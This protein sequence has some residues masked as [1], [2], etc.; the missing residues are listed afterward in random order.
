[1][2]LTSEHADI[3]HHLLSVIQVFHASEHFRR[4]L[5][6]VILPPNAEETLEWFAAWKGRGADVVSGSVRVRQ[7]D[8]GTPND[9]RPQ[10]GPCAVLRHGWERRFYPIS[11]QFA[12][13]LRT[14]QIAQR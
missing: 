5:V 13:G 9:E 3:L 2:R 8:R 12:C 7:C 4:V 11:L 14:R 1:M 6:R 10:I